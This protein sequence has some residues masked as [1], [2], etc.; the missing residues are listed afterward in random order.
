MPAHSTRPR[1]TPKAGSR[2]ASGTALKSP[3]GAALGALLGAALPLGGPLGLP[4]GGAYAQ[5]ASG[6]S[7]AVTGPVERPAAETSATVKAWQSPANFGEW[8]S[9][10]KLGLQLQGGIV[11]NPTVPDRGVNFGQLFTDLPNR[12]LLNQLILSAARDIDPKATGYDFGFKLALLYGSDA[13]IIQTLGIFD[14]LIHDR[15]QLALLEASVTARLPWLG[16]G[17]DVKVGNFPTPLGFE[18]IDPKTNAFY[19]RSYIFNY[20]LPLKHTGGMA[21]AHVSDVL[22]LYI[23]LDSGTNTSFG[24]GGDNNGRPAGLAGFGL[25]LAGGNLTVLALTHIG[26]ENPTR[27]TP[28]GNSALRYFND[29]VVTYKA[30]EQLSFTTELNYVK[31][32]GFRAEGYGVAQYASYALNDQIT[33]NGRAEVWRDNGN[34]YV[35][36]PNSNRDFANVQRGDYATLITSSRAGTYFELTLGV[37]YKPANLP[38]PLSTLLVRPEIRY[39]RTLNDARPFNGGRN[40]QQFTVGA[41]LVLGF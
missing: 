21:I 39:D 28:F 25:N 3:F 30:T 36:N 40:A 14:R 20:G 7:G 41:D 10:I 2:A 17:I 5:T 4:S 1:A 8:S 18:T 29:V 19:T 13:R 22:D 11:G 31:D 33:L 6:T 38:G 26:P 24:R 27:S 12:P 34:F 16:N 23:G 35:F 9:G 32:D 37:T 15:N